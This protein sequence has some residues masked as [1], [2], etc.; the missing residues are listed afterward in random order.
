M[1]KR[2]SWCLICHVYKLAPIWDWTN[3]SV[4]KVSDL[5]T[6]TSVEYIVLV[7]G[8]LYAKLV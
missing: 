4:P 7:L 1:E 5:L 2:L 3:I 6:L 8:I